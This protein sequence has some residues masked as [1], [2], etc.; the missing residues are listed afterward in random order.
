MEQFLQCLAELE[1]EADHLLLARH[2]VSIANLFLLNWSMFSYAAKKNSR[3]TLEI[4]VFC[5]IRYFCYVGFFFFFFFGKLEV[6]LY[7]N[8]EFEVGN[9]NQIIIIIVTIKQSKQLCECRRYD[10]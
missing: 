5:I 8:F 10:G 9:H 7:E 3:E 6:A 2:Q 4:P 1:I